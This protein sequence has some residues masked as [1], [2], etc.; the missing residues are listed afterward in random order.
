MGS[1]MCIRDS[2]YIVSFPSTGSEIWFGGLDTKE[3][4]EKVFGQEYASI[5][6]NEA[7]QLSP[8]TVDKVETRLAQK[9]QGFKNFM[10]YDCNPRH[11]EHFLYKKFYI[12][13]QSYQAQLLWT[14]HDNV[15]NLSPG[16]IERLGRK[17]EIS[18]ARF[19]EGKWVS[20]PGAVYPGVKAE[21]IITVDKDFRFYDDIA[22]GLDFGLNTAF[23]LWAFKH[24]KAYCMYEITLVGAKESTTKNIISKISVIWWL[25]KYS[26]P[27]YCD[28]EP[29]R[30]SELIDAGFNAKKAPKDVGAGDSTVNEHELFF[31]TKCCN[32]FQSMLNLVH[33]VDENDNFID[34]HVKENDHHADASRYAQH[35]RKVDNAGEGHYFF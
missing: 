34:K 19:L 9:V 17:D 33:Q 14:P 23:V 13:K 5:F 32:T 35:G 29:D 22:C 12:E 26:V 30:I 10:I 21:N 16:Y 15:K 27:I 8:S 25:R 24:N 18:R 20:L 3:R 7:V 4:A 2:D 31:D 1:E 28:H 6:L 11:P